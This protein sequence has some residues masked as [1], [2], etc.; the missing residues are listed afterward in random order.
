MGRR[1]SHTTP[2][3][4]M[5]ITSVKD[6]HGLVEIPVF[7]GLER[8]DCGWS[9]GHFQII[10]DDMAKFVSGADTDRMLMYTCSKRSIMDLT[11]ADV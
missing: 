4:Y 6:Q 5:R 9:A 7:V 11:I 1:P 3:T 10:C 8:R 2:T